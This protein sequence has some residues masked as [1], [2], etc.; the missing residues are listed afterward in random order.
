M[1][2]K[3]KKMIVPLF[4]TGCVLLGY[5]LWLS[6]RPVDII[7]VHHRSSGFS[8]V[9][10]TTFPPTDK[11]K[12]KWWLKNKDMIEDRYDIPKPDKDGYFYLTLWLF[13]EGY[14]EEEKY[15]RLCFKDMKKPVNCIEKDRVFSISSSKN[16]GLIFTVD[17]GEYRMGKDGKIIKL[18]GE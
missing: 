5:W 9:L 2:V 10:V 17:N 15:D 3:K 16:R 4:L 7:A 1:K 12:I 13:E 18:K 6:L 11:G 8:D 14:K